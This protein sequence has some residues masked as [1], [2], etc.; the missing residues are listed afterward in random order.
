MLRH[1]GAAFYENMEC[2]MPPLQA[3]VDCLTRALAGGMEPGEVNARAQSCMKE[4]GMVLP[5]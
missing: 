2:V 5:G 1:D 4:A 3:A